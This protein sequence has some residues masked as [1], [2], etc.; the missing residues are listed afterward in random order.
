MHAKYSEIDAASRAP[1]EVAI[2]PV[3]DVESP[4]PAQR[5]E[6]SSFLVRTYFLLRNS[7]LLPKKELHSRVW[8]EVRRTATQ[9]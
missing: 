2:D 9:I 4:V 1:R 5:L 7:N 8:V 3:Q 6:C